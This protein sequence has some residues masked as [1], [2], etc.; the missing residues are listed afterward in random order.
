MQFFIAKLVRYTKE[1][2]DLCT[3]KFF[4]LL[5]QIVF[6]LLL[7]SNWTVCDAHDYGLG[8]TSAL[9]YLLFQHFR[10][11]YI[12]PVMMWLKTTRRKCAGKKWSLIGPMERLETVQY[13]I[14]AIINWR[15][16]ICGRP[17]G[18]SPWQ[19]KVPFN[20]GARVDSISIGHGHGVACSSYY[21]PGRQTNNEVC[22][23][24]EAQQAYCLALATMTADGQFLRR[25]YTYCPLLAAEAEGPKGGGVAKMGPRFKCP[26]WLECEMRSFK[27]IYVIYGTIGLPRRCCGGALKR[28]ATRQIICF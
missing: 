4:I 26:S 17:L 20:F 10:P 11:I 14:A 27:T 2:W 8:H 24:M 9:H 23:W 3:N 12:M 5:Q 6:L 22:N 21:A 1:L 25:S 19:N 28:R 13:T 7:L 16:W 18:F 15:L